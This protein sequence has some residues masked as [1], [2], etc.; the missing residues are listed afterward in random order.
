HEQRI[1]QLEAITNNLTTEE[2]VDLTPL[3]PT[4][5]SDLRLAKLETAITEPLTLLA[6]NLTQQQL[7]D[8]TLSFDLN[9]N[10]KVNQLQAETVVA[11]EVKVKNE[12]ENEKIL[13]EVT[14]LQGEEEAIVKTEKLTESSKIFTS[15]ASNPEAFSWT[16][17]VLDEE[18]V[19]G[20]R[21]ILSEPAKKDL[22]VSWWV[23]SED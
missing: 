20:F 7:Q 5:N 18:E 4:N 1:R 9:G 19:I 23:I 11:G 13:G 17:K 14:I 10:L 3:Q 6:K 12:N 8:N 2:L 21:I 15:F 16:E 22:K